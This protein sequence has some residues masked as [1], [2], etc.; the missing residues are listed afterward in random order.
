MFKIQGKTF[1]STIKK[2]VSGT[3]VV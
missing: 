1:I 2:M 3:T